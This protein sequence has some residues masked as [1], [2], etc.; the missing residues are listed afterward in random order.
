MVR[1]LLTVAA[2]GV[3]WIVK[4]RSVFKERPEPLE[5][6]LLVMG[7]KTVLMVFGAALLAT[8]LLQAV[9]EEP[10]VPSAAFNSTHDH[11]PPAV[12]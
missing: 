3:A 6:D 5:R 1:G 9:A 10:E 11:L 8:V 2:L 7:L 4:R 12:S